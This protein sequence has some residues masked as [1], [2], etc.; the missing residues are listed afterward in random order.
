[1]ACFHTFFW[2]LLFQFLFENGIPGA[3]KSMSKPAVATQNQSN[4]LDSLLNAHPAFFGKITADPEKYEVQII[5]TRIIRDQ[6]NRPS[7]EHHYYGVNSK[8]YFNPASLVKLPVAIL[9]LEK[10]RQL[11]KPGLTRNSRMETGVAGPCQSAVSA[12]PKNRNPVPTPGRYISRM[13]LVS[14]NN[15]YNRLYEFLGQ[16]YLNKRLGGWGFP[17]ARILQRFAGCSQAANRCTNPIRFFTDNRKLL[18]A[19]PPAC[20]PEVLQNPLGFVGKGKAHNRGGKLIKAPYDFTYSNYLP[21][22]AVHQ[23]LMSVMFPEQMENSGTPQLEPQDYRFLRNNLAR[24][25]EESEFPE[26]R[27]SPQYFPAYKKYLYYGADSEAKPQPGLRIFNVVGRSFGF[28]SDCAY[29]ADFESGT[30]FFLS[31]VIYVNEDEIINNGRYEYRS[32]GLPFLGNLGKVI[33]Q[34]EKEQKKPFKPDL[35]AFQVQ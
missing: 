15:S 33:Y 34:Y 14:D 7:F 8:Q 21:L 13:L 32:I 31:A 12:F 35:S 16:E 28:V 3:Q 25:P 20:N 23:M 10:L 4:L 1:M 9:T 19:Q 29:F 17:E 26:Y 22:Q 30:E 5:F 2:W 11:Q 27:A 6:H 18:Y 24:Q